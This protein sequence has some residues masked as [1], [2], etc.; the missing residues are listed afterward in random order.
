MFC[1][2]AKELANS[3]YGVLA[4][5]L[6]TGGKLPCM[7]VAQSVTAWGRWHIKEVARMV[8][9][10]YDVNLI[11]GDTDSVIIHLYLFSTRST[12]DTEIIDMCMDMVRY[13][14]ATLPPFMKIEFENV[15]KG[16]YVL[17]AKKHYAG[18]LYVASGGRLTLA[19]PP[20]DIKYQGL[21]CKRNDYP[22]VIAETQWHAIRAACSL[23]PFAKKNFVLPLPPPAPPCP[24]NED[25]RV[26]S[27]RHII[28]YQ[29]QQIAKDNIPLDGYV[30]HKQVVKEEYKSKP[31]H[32]VLLERLQRSFGNEVPFGK[33]DSIPYVFVKEG[34]Q[35][36]PFLPDEVRARGIQP[37][38]PYYFDEFAKVML[39]TFDVVVGADVL[40]SHFNNVVVL[41]PRIAP[42]SIFSKFLVKK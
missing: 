27:V 29:A 22:P 14:N 32:I 13:I 2:A 41:P 16:G 35:L 25:A 36:A 4:A 24:A 1:K 18:S 17:T 37:Y 8:E 19:A 33:G 26:W 31:P 9:E 30:T 38:R 10:K 39:R 23:P 20:K 28:F 3:K 5:T 34:R 40:N 7:P 15:F 42:N 6:A 11:A 12:T 21:E